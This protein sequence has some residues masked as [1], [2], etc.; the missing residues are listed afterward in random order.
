MLSSRWDRVTEVTP[1]KWQEHLLSSYGWMAN[2]SKFSETEQD[3]LL[4]LEKK[5]KDR[6]SEET[7]E[8]ARLK[9]SKKRCSKKRLAEIAHKL[10]PDCKFRDNQADAVLLSIYAMDVWIK[11]S[12]LR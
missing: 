6:T 8:M 2:V 9:S 7:V 11:N 5:K 10:F 4:W 12:S 3:R 1:V